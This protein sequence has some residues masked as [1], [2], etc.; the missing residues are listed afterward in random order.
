M[1]KYKKQRKI[2]GSDNFESKTI[3]K[4]LVQVIIGFQNKLQNEELKKPKSRQK[5]ISFVYASLELS[6]RMNK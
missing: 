6:R 2:V 4:P 1:A 3:A 5:K